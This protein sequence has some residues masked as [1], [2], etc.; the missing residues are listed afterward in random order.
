MAGR[1]AEEGPEQ[2]RVVESA[3]QGVRQLLQAE[4]SAESSSSAVQHC[5]VRAELAFVFIIS[6]NPSGYAVPAG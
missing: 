6:D 4:R 1:V 2:W 3:V 5:Q